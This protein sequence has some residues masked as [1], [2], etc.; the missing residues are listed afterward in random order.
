M[1]EGFSKKEQSERPRILQLLR[2]FHPDVLPGQAAEAEALTKV[3]TALLDNGQ[4][5]PRQFQGQGVIIVFKDEDDKVVRSKS[6]YTIPSSSKQ[7]L[8]DLEFILKNKKFP[9]QT[10]H[11]YEAPPRPTKP[12]PEKSSG[13]PRPTKPQPGKSPGYSS[14]SKRTSEGQ[15]K[16]SELIDRSETLRDLQRISD[17]MRD[18]R[19]FSRLSH[20]DFDSLSLKLQK[21]VAGIFSRQLDTP[22]TLRDLQR[23][24]D[25][26]RDERLF[27]RLS[28]VDFDSL[29]LKLKTKAEASKGNKNDPQPEKPSWWKR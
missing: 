18:E 10:A 20:V 2:R 24:S 19:L 8:S 27:S 21:K 11:T 13:H 16:F 17:M 22:T 28:H 25:M 12:Q 1:P 14:E 4:S 3:L 23:I 6:P 9:V 5:M 29:S 15:N 26:M 7:F